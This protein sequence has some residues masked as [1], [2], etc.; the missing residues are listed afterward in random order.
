MSKVELER[1]GKTAAPRI[2]WI[3]NDAAVQHKNGS[4]S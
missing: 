2:L 1:V 4:A 3:V